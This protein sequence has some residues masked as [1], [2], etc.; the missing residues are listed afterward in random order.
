[1]GVLVCAG[2]ATRAEAYTCIGRAL[3]LVFQGG[4]AGRLTQ[5]SSS[6]PLLQ[7]LQFCRCYCPFDLPTAT[8]TPL[9]PLRVLL[10]P[11]SLHRHLPLLQQLVPLVLRCRGYR[12]GDCG[13][14]N[15]AH[16]S[17]RQS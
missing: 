11:P 6:M 12:V 13:D 16:H 4:A 17:G 2:T 5:T 7:L 9:P 1:M 14:H 10:L 3:C 15:D 8:R